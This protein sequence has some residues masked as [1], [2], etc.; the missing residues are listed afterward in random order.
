MKIFPILLAASLFIV[1]GCS[2]HTE[3]EKPVLSAN[4][5]NI[6]TIESSELL[7]SNDDDLDSKECLIGIMGGRS[8]VDKSMWVSLDE[9][10]EGVRKGQ[11][12]TVMLTD[13]LEEQVMDY[14][15]CDRFYMYYDDISI[16]DE[17]LITT[18]YKIVL[19]E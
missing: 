2:S 16:S 12:V 15:I 10:I 14:E 9:D 11:A 5:E 6:T 8:E 19:A 7:P 1:V 3:M 18:P 17:P 13:E 4:E